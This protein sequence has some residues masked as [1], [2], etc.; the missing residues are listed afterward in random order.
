[1][2]HLQPVA[3]QTLGSSGEVR[4]QFVSLGEAAAICIGER[5]M[6][7]A[8]TPH[9]A[10]HTTTSASMAGLQGV[11]Q[12][13]FQP[14]IDHIDGFQTVE[15]TQPQAALTHDQIGTLDEVKSKSGGEVAVLDIRRVPRA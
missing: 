14:A 15:R 11:E 9:D 12:F 4:P 10:W 7:A 1:M 6:P 13:V 5:D 3:E 2:I 8:R